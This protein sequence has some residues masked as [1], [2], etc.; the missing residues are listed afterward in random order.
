MTGH[1]PGHHAPE[2]TNRQVASVLKMMA[3][4]IDIIGDDTFRA[5]SY[6]RAARS[7]ENT[8]ELIVD[9]YEKDELKS[10]PGVGA[11]IARRVSE[12]IETGTA[13]ALEEMREKVPAGV[14]DLLLVPGIGPRSA[15]TLYNS[16]GIAS[17]D[18][19]E[20]AAREGRVQKLPR[21]GR[22][23]EEKIL[24][25]IAGLRE[26]TRRIPLGVARPAALGLLEAVRRLPGVTD[27]ALAGSFRRGRD[28]VKD[29]DIVAAGP[30]PGAIAAAFA[31]L[32]VVEEVIGQ[33][34]TK[35]SVRVDGP[36]PGG[37][38]ADLRTVEPD[39]FAAALHHFT[40]SAAHH[41]GLR[42]RAKELGLK[43]NEYG[44]FRDDGRK[45]PVATEAELYAH[46][47]MDYIPPELR[48]DRGEIDAALEGRLPRLIGED[49]IRGDLHTH[50]SWSDGRLPIDQMAAAARDRGLRYIAITDHSQSLTV[51]GGLTE[52]RLRQQL[53]EIEGLRSRLDGIHVL[54]GIEV[55]I[56][57]DGTLDL[58]DE[59]LGLLDVVV[60]SVHSH[61]QQD[62]D[63]M[64]ERIIKAMENPHVDILGHPTGRILGYR[65]PYDVDVDAL[66]EAAVQTR[67]VLEI[68]SSPERLDLA[69]EHVFRGRTLGAKFAVNTD[70]HGAAGLEVLPFGI[71]TARRGW[72]EEDDVINAWPLER[73][74]AFL[75]KPK[76]SRW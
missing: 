4:Y 48:E 3:D 18:D 19:L 33:G 25:E 15:S 67:T 39:A 44:V 47:G 27:A 42:G 61:F 16:L 71:L 2:M 23:T 30:D 52:E 54:T 10:I 51:A 8:P 28:A 24:K 60:A 29:I 35:V 9:L 72:L 22:R 53:A 17:L 49:G 62:R 32:E 66:L 73:L 45:L 58:S 5:S 40:G 20:A 55:D 74:T 70:A 57:Q 41:L 56:L 50:S 21:F 12:I 14:L 64:T 26:R 65:D 63:V 68:N 46:L 38:G 37:L 75:K 13:A 36:W 6:R 11:S 34:D 43:I 76:K 59:V 31:G 1:G 69:D 7:I